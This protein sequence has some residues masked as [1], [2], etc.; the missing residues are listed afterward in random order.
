MSVLQY[1][2]GGKK[3]TGGYKGYGLGLMVD[4]LS[5]VL[6]GANFGSRLAA[7]K[8]PDSHANIGHFFGAL[9]LSGFR[10]IDEFNEDFDS[11]V[12]D[13]KSSPREP[14]TEKIFIPGEPEIIARSENRRKG[15]PVLPSVLEKLEHIAL[16]LGLEIPQ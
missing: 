2:L 7:S 12:R 13:L 3:I 14:D 11:L 15:V 16:E 6:S 9:K 8:R 10:P 4:V 5:G 1:P